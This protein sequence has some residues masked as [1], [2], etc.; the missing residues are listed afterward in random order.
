LKRHL[1]TVAM[2]LVLAGCSGVAQLDESP[3]DKEAD[4]QANAFSTYLSARFAAG[5]H[6]MPEAARY[7][8]QSLKN[9]PGNAE[10][11]SQAF[12]FASTSGDMESAGKFATAMVA[13]SPDERS[14]RL[15]LAVVAFKHKDYAGARKNLSL[16]AKGPFQSLVVSLFDAWGAAASNDAAGAMADMKS[17]GAQSGVEGLAAFHTALI[18]DYLGQADVDAAYKKALVANRV[19]PRVIEAYGN[20]LERAGRGTDAQALYEKYI[21]EP[22]VA[23]IVQSG[24]T[25]LAQNKKPAPF[26]RSAEDG[27]AEGLFG[28]AASLSDQSSAEVSILY[29]RMALYLRPDLA[30]ANLLLADRFET[31]GKFEEAVSIYRDIDKA[32]PYFPMAATQA[33]VDE[34]RLDHKA[35]AIADLKSLA[36]AYPNSS[37]NWIALGDAY[38]DQDNDD[39]AIAAYDRATK[40]IG[41]PQK[42]DW[43]LFYARAMAQDRAKHWDKAEVDV[44]EALKLSPDQPELL[45][46]LGYSWV[47][48]NEKIPEALTML[49]KARKL[50]PYD[51]YIVDSVGW[52]YY[53]LGR[54]DDA[55]RTLEAAVLLVPGD[56]TINEHL[57][58]ALW[59]SGRRMDARFQWN[60]ALAFATADT[61]KAAIEQKIKNGLAG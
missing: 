36:E 20:Y 61:D 23:P 5:Q 59:K 49:E 39:Q 58:D 22:G 44:N 30:L 52:A 42:R 31:L 55:A 34:T 50:R 12:F 24:L 32:S 54:Y 57:G 53:R 7:Y 25:R 14:A 48:R 38:R 43:P 17:L 19:S 45:N 4:R 28:I 1:F 9:D 47:D 37:E 51:G 2:F 26:I 41:T 35:A 10:I 29:L 8:A 3:A 27:V 56:S 18:A 6:E 46:Y 13:K 15:T 60:H 11:M 33:A 16:S 40:T 21:T